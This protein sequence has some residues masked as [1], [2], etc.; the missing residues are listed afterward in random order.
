MYLGHRDLIIVPK[1]I[2]A[3]LIIHAGER[4]AAYIQCT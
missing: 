3:E 4:I 1:H 2:L